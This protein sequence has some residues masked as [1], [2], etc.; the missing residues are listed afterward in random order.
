[1][2][3]LGVT[4]RPTWV[5]ALHAQHWLGLLSQAHALQGV[6]LG[7]PNSSGVGLGL[8]CLSP[9]SLG[10]APATKPEPTGCFFSYL[11]AFFGSI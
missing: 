5:C 7:L 6:G 9:L 8:P 10:W 11:G 2:L 1:M 4:A 3:I